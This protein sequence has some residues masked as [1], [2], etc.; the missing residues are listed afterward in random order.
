MNLGRQW[1]ACKVFQPGK[2]SEQVVHL[3]RQQSQYPALPLPT[4]QTLLGAPSDQLDGDAR[5]GE[6][7]G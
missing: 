3:G 1:L 7:T 5:M 4:P 6:G 2:K